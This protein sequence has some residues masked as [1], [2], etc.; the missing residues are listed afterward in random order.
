M[1]KKMG[2]LREYETLVVL[3]P[4]LTDEATDAVLARL[5]ELLAKL[6]AHFLREDRWGKRKLSFEVKKHGR[7]NF[8]LLHYLADSSV[9]EEFERTLRNLDEVIRFLTT[10]HGDVADVEAKKAEVE[11]MV[12][13]RAA[14]KARA[15]A[16]R[17]ARE[18]AMVAEAAGQSDE[19]AEA[20]AAQ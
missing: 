19:G 7:G 20:Q 3:N 12:R 5:T 13:E 11:K 9:I 18:E 16:E 6:N 4:E 1:S 14:D 15:E 10:L 17:K 2:K 8:I